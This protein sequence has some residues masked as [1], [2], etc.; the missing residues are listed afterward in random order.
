VKNNIRISVTDLQSFYSCPRYW[1]W[2]RTWG[3]KTPIVHFWVGT[4]VH[5]GLD[6]YF[7]HNRSSEACLDGFRTWVSKS[8]SDLERDQGEYWELIRDEFLTWGEKMFGIL[9]NFVAY[10]LSVHPKYLQGRI[11][12]VEEKL[13]LEIFPG[14]D[15]VMKADLILEDQE[16]L[17]VIDHKTASR[18]FSQ[19]AVDLDDQ[20]TAYVCLTSIIKQRLIDRAFYNVI[21]KSVPQPPTQLTRGGL[22]KSK[23]QS[24]T[25]ALYLNEIHRL[26]LDPSDYEDILSHFL[27]TGWSQYFREVGTYR[28]RTE[29]EAFWIRA[30]IKCHDILRA[31]EEPDVYAFPNPSSYS[32]STCQFKIPCKLK[33]EGLDYESVLKANFLESR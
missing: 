20:L 25:Y 16:G 32:C 28:N 33:N 6:M 1:F 31:I 4:G 14:V 29:L 9:E 23:S 18:D 3:P 22:S 15:L 12:S 17:K 8:L 10:D 26:G 30:S 24:T 13:V 27:Q 19:E 21:Y 2:G 5:E 7:R 11:E